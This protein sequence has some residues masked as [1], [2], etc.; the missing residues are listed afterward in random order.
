MG[1]YGM[2]LLDP[3]GLAV[4]Q[5]PFRV[6]FEQGPFE[7]GIRHGR[8]AGGFVPG[9][10]MRRAVGSCSSWDGSAGLGSR[11]GWGPQRLFGS[12]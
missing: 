5:Q 8:W 11:W 4:D 7:E 9:P 6:G 10:A 3:I 12:G 2:V 1:Q